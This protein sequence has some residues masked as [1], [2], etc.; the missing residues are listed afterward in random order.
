MANAKN[1]DGFTPTE[2]LIMEVM[3]ARWRLGIELWPFPTAFAKTIRKL[4]DDGFV[5]YKDGNVEN[6]L[7]VA[8]TSQ[9][10]SRMKLHRPFRPN[11]DQVVGRVWE[12]KVN[13]HG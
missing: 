6:T 9:G 10:A 5:W 4:E 2:Y 8:I 1:L 7:L 11:G 12:M 13:S 3:A